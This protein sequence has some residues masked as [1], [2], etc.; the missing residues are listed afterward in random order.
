MHDTV[1]ILAGRAA[2]HGEHRVRKVTKV[3]VLV[4]VRTMCDVA[5]EILRAWACTSTRARARVQFATKR[6]FGEHASVPIVA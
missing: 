5:K 6:A 3:R 1:P 2:E 4:E